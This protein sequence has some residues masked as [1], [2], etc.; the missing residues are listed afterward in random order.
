MLSINDL[1]ALGQSALLDHIREMSDA[2]LCALADVFYSSAT[3]K[4]ILPSSV[5]LQIATRLTILL[6]GGHHA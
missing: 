1:R 5:A 4:E 2:D 6:Q 3:G